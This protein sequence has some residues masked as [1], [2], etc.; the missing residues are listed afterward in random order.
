MC[1]R[2]ARAAVAAG[3]VVPTH[4]AAREAT[5]AVIRENITSFRILLER[6]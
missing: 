5:E 4:H 3:G 1:D 2:D 6:S